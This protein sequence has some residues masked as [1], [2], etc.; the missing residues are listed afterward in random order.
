MLSR[1]FRGYQRFVG[2]PTATQVRW[3]TASTA[4]LAPNRSAVL[5]PKEKRQTARPKKAAKTKKGGKGAEALKKA[6]I[7]LSAIN[8]DALPSPSKPVSQMTT[9][10]QLDICRLQYLE[11][12]SRGQ[13]MAIAIADGCGIG[14]NILDARGHR[15]LMRGETHI[16][17]YFRH[18]KQD[19][20]VRAMATE[21]APVEEH[22]E[23]ADVTTDATSEKQAG[24][25]TTK[26]QIKK[27]KTV[28]ADD[29]PLFHKAPKADPNDK[30]RYLFT[31]TYFP[32]ESAT[33]EALMI[34]GPNF[35][36]LRKIA[37]KFCQTV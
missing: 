17:R 10:E 21:E 13:Q 11:Q 34:N 30:G 2:P 20:S 29:E 19:G 6:K 22:E 18:I 12:F 37:Q 27:G 5:R 1:S 16:R 3:M 31:L 14:A 32:P 33:A 8:I 23:S 15:I 36:A 26:K 9:S 7:D 35:L 24:A 25:S 28:Q 4:L